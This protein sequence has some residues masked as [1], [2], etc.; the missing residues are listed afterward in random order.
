MTIWHLDN[1]S[2]IW[3][4]QDLQKIHKPKNLKHCK[5]YYL[6]KNHFHFLSTFITIFFNKHFS[7]TQGSCNGQL[8]SWFSGQ[9]SIL[10]FSALQFPSERC[11]WT[12]QRN[13]VSTIFLIIFIFFFYGSHT[14]LPEGDV[15]GFGNYAWGFKK[16]GGNF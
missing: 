12:L 5:K 2:K 9:I 14:F 7:G 11:P 13:V 15:Q 8:L 1:N 10:C 3:F 16:I 6:K 4:Y